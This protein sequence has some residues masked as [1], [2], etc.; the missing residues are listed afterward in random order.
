M[1]SLVA[2][3]RIT[4]SHVGYEDTPEGI[5]HFFVEHEGWRP[6]SRP[7]HL[8]VLP[9]G[10]TVQRVPL[11]Q[12]AY[13]AGPR[14]NQD[15]ASIAIIGDWRTE[16]PPEHVWG[17]TVSLAA[18][19]CAIYGWRP[20]GRPWIERARREAHRVSGHGE[21]TSKRC[22]GQRWD[23]RRFR[24]AVV[25]RLDDPSPGPRRHRGGWALGRL[26]GSVAERAGRLGI[27]A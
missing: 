22:P 5:E 4:V 14:W 9:T 23:M 26:G 2:L 7:Y 10:E 25:R 11:S 8:Y 13:H 18:S 17:S 21:L 6:T 20:W 19:L 27:A 12:V 24:G 1:P 16:D 3:H 15:A